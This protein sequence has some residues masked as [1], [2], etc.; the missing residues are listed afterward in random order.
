[1]KDFGAVEFQEKFLKR[2]LWAKQKEICYAATIGPR[3]VTSIKGCHGSGKT[4]TVSGLVP[5]E[6]LSDRQS[7]VLTIAPT[8]RQVKLMW[9]EIATAIQ[10]LKFRGLPEPATTSWKFSDTNYALGFSSSKGVNAQGFHAKKILILADEAI[11]ISPDLWDAV[12]GIRA[13]GDVRLVR[14]CN[15][16]VPN[17]APFEDFSRLRNQTNCITISA[18]DTPNLAGLT[19]ETLLQLSEEELDYAPFPWL[20]RRRWVK[21]MYYKWGPTNPR[22]LSRVLGEFPSQADNSVFSLE[23]I[24]KA[25]L[26]LEDG[27]AEKEMKKLLER[28]AIPQVGVD[29][30][31]P[32]EDE[33]SAHARLGPYI[34]AHQA[35]NAPDARGNVVGFLNDI[36]KR[37]DGVR[38]IVVVDTVGIGFHM[39]THLMDHRYDVRPFVAGARARDPGMFANWKAEAYWGLREQMKLGHVKGLE[40]EDTKAQLSDIRYR[41]TAAGRIEIESKDEARNRGAN[42]PDRAESLVM[43]FSC[44]MDIPQPERPWE[45]NQRV[46]ISRY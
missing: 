22:F 33:T 3:R 34:M 36:R 29:V 20:T 31:G 46:Q 18:F 28:G 14:L 16:T 23:W 27:E 43:A 45:G 19:L 41:E 35:W 38:P 13:A 6:L 7:V 12:E 17:G 21:E 1:V 40:D 30:A 4:F 10:A 39:G 25:S 9:N 24:E 26:L 5:H 15:P 37:C 2:K 8:L 44:P 32:G 11:G 42:S